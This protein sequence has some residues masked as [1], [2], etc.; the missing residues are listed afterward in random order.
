M[1]VGTDEADATL[2]NALSMSSQFA[3]KMD[4]AAREIRRVVDV[5][6]GWKKHFASHGVRKN[7]IA[8]LVEQIDR[9]FLADQRRD[10]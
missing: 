10:C 7:D 8:Q 6:A 9:P 1:R 2:T 4:A 3:L 5:V